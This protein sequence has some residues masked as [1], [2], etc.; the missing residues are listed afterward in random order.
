MRMMMVRHRGIIGDVA[1]SIAREEAHRAA[2][3]PDDRFH[4][5][6]RSLRAP[7]GNIWFARSLKPTGLYR[8]ESIRHASSVPPRR[9]FS[10]IY[11][12]IP[13]RFHASLKIAFDSSVDFKTG[14]SFPPRWHANWDAH[15]GTLAIPEPSTIEVIEE[16]CKFSGDTT[17][18]S[19]A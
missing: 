11:P 18:D 5:L 1:R 3:R 7:Y 14:S 8:V 6:N 19:R 15:F 12:D 10:R 2:S 9:P 16:H 4:R 13:S 17:L